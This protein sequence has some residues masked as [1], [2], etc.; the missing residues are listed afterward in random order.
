MS[1]LQH[2]RP[3]WEVLSDFNNITEEQARNICADFTA[4]GLDTPADGPASEN[5]EMIDHIYDALESS[6]I[7]QAMLGDEEVIIT[8]DNNDPFYYNAKINPADTHRYFVD[9]TLTTKDPAF[10]CMI[11]WVDEV[12]SNGVKLS[13]SQSEKPCRAVFCRDCVTPWVTTCVARCP[14]CR[15][16]CK[17]I[18][19]LPVQVTK[20]PPAQASNKITVVIRRKQRAPNTSASID[21]PVI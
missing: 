17:P 20:K 2:S 13:C 10:K 21:N 11:C 3:V 12:V 7:R 1:V 4:A 9:H 19:N 6:D 15:V 14:A 16:F 8:E 18:Q 5:Q